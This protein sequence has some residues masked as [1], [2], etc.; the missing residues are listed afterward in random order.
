MLISAGLVSYM[1]A[2][3]MAYRDQVGGVRPPADPW[4][5]SSCWCA[6]CH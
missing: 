5:G 4:A 3:T 6:C 2:F 1:G